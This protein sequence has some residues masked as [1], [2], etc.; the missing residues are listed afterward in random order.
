MGPNVSIE[1][2]LSETARLTRDSAGYPQALLGWLG[3]AA[4][5]SVAA[6]GNLD[7]LEHDK[8]AFFCSVK[9]PG[10]LILQTYDV[11][12]ALRD[13][14][15]TVV[16]GFH[17]PMEEE[18]LALLLRGSQPIIICP[19]RGIEGMRVP[20]DWKEPLDQGRL[21]L[22]SPFERKQRRPT[23]K[24]ALARNEFVAAL[25]DVVLFAHA[26][27]GGKTE[28]LC[29]RAVEW[30]KPALALDDDANAGLIALGAHPV[31]PSDVA[32]LWQRE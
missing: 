24:L 7:I 9:C 1:C 6:R 14:G 10:S 15:V 17:S 21:L 13:A 12:C 4:P 32:E 8:L 22:L 5:E 3:D 23:V 28:D 16:S 19:A 2:L 18:C 31:A 27:P 30:G 25:G 11:A 20:R 29:R 26:E